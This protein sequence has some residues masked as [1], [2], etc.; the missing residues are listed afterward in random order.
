MTFLDTVYAMT[1]IHNESKFGETCRK[2][3]QV[4]GRSENKEA[5]SDPSSVFTSQSKLIHSAM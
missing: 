3:N 2:N 5:V 1:V 4:F